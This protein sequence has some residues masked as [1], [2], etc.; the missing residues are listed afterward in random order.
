MNSLQFLSFIQ[1]FRFLILFLIT[2]R[3]D[4]EAL[5]PKNTSV[6]SYSP[7]LQLCIPPLSETL[8]LSSCLFKPSLFWLV[9]LHLSMMNQF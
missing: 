6:A 3:I 9:S 7:V 2:T 1:I 4:L 8:C 5:V